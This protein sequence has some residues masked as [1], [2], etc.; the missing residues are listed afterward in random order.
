MYVLVNEMGKAS[1]TEPTIK[2]RACE[3]KNG[4]RGFQAYRLNR[5]P[6]ANKCAVSFRGL[7]QAIVEAGV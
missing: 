4:W 1:G 7:H 6:K 2:L 3:H 5:R